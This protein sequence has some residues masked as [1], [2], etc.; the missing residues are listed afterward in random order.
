MRH[1][2]WLGEKRGLDRKKIAREGGG[3]SA[4]TD[5]EIGL[6]LFNYVP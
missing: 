4:S 2:G 3:L 6:A 5:E 1:E